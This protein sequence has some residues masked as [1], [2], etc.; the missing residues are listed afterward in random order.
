MISKWRSAAAG[1]ALMVLAA[2]QTTVGDDSLSAAVPTAVN[3]EEL[4]GLEEFVDGVMAGQVVSREVAGATIAVVHRGQLLFSRGYGF[5]D[6]DAREKVDADETL[7][8]PGSVSKLFTWTA[9]MQQIEMGRVALDNDVNHYIDFSIPPFEGQPILVRHLMSHSPGMSDIGG[10]S[11]KTVEELTPYSE[12]IKTHVPE[13]VWA[14]GTEIAYSNY[15]VALAGYIVEQVSREPFADYVENH[16]FEPLGM[17]STTFREPL[18]DR[19]AS[20]MA[21]G[22]EVEEGRLVAQPFELYSSI[23]PAGSSSSTA[24]DM[25]RFMMAMLGEGRLGP[26]RILKPESV[27]LLMSDSMA[28][29]SGLPGMAHGFYVIREANPR[30]VGH[31]GNTGDFHSELIL[32]PES[33]FGLFVSVT[34]GDKSSRARTDLANAVIGRL[35]PQAPAPRVAAPNDSTPPVG[36]Y[37]AN[38][39]NYARDPRTEFDI[40][41]AAAE[42]DAIVVTRQEEV[43]YWERI[44]PM[45]YERVTGAREGG[46]YDRIRFYGDEDNLMMSYASQP[47]LAYRRVTAASAQ[48][49]A[50]A[51]VPGTTLAGTSFTQ[52]KDW[53]ITIEGPVTV[54][55]APESDLDVAVVEVGAATGARDAAAKAWSL[56]D[57]DEDRRVR[58]TTPAAP[59]DGWAERVNISY[60]TS[61]AEQAVVSA[62]SLRRDEAWTVLIV[63]GSQATANKRSAAVSL[64]QQALR[65]AGYERENFAG[66]EAHRLD[67][68]RVRVLRDFVAESARTL[69]VPGVALA[70]IDQGEVVWEG[71]IG[72][73]ALG[74]RARVDADTKF[75][76]ASN[77]KGMSTL[78]LS[79]LADEGKL[80]WDQRVVDLYPSFRLGDDSTTQAT[81]VRHLVCA[82]TGLP[83]KD[84]AFILADQGAPASDT[85]RQLAETQPTSDFGELFQ[86]N[87]LMAAAAGYLA[88]ALA[89]PEMELGAAYDKAMEDRIF[90]PLGMR[91]TTFDFDE[92]MSGNWARPHGLDVDG[93]MTV[94]SNR[95]NYAPYPYRPAGGAFSSVADMAR[96]VQLELSRGLTP[97]GERLVSEEN[98]LERRVRGVQISEDRWYGMGVFSEVDSG[99]PVV[100]HGGTLLGY[101]SNWYVLPEAGV[102]AVILTN[103]DPGAAMLQPFMHRLLEVLYDGRPEAQ[104]AVKVAAAR[105]KAQAAARRQNLTIPGDPEFVG[106]LARRYESP[107]IGTITLSNKKGVKWIKAGSIEGPVATRLNPD[108]TVSLISIGPGQI[109]VEALIG[110]EDGVRTLTIRDSQHEY[111]Y[112]EVH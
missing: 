17:N 99:V 45:I 87:N 28:N 92:G 26:A 56:Y 25:A 34:G 8:R 68:D 29:T 66:K 2:P 53:T 13:R 27:R 90:A 75:M 89:Y 102:G 96:Y 81:L 61:P 60:Q 1:L 63:Y 52:P 98:L 30:L 44:G 105:I 3:S 50:R 48:E 109:N 106:G 54:F 107:G 19:L 11:A 16:I 42:S 94:M 5:S 88:G 59:A 77:T 101:H 93:R 80:Q 32:A 9:L 95:F 85:F 23:M 49:A 14:P 100:S 108:G 55:S 58:L 20:R 36:S 83:R 40:R 112:T 73:R 110:N 86:Y 24:T 65:P 69:E 6:I 46:P 35:F 70:L 18:P 21:K 104:Q 82:C 43:S 67:P 33:E 71:G 51:D 97:D 62:L 22:Y 84:W 38:R 76:I 4:E 15:G 72:I 39:R 10:I 91:D 37:R 12:W 47:Y 74:S 79:I 57:P 103:A 111:R 31:G 41:V 78:L 7:F 64:A